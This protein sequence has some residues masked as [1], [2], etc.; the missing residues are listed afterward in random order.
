MINAHFFN[1]FLELSKS[2][3]NCQ[4]VMSDLSNNIP[5]WQTE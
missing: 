4:T 5:K 1:D 2:F 3:K